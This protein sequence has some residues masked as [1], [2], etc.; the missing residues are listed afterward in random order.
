[1]AAISKNG[2]A[3]GVALSAFSLSACAGAISPIGSAD[4]AVRHAV[5]YTQRFTYRPEGQSFV[6]PGQITSITVIAIGAEGGAA[7]NRDTLGG[8]VHAVIPVVPFEVLKVY[9]GGSGA[10]L[11][12]GFNGGGNGGNSKRACACGYGGGGASDVRA[13]GDGLSDRIIVAAGGGGQGG[14]GS[15]NVGGKGGR[16]GGKHGASGLPGQSASSFE[17]GSGGSGGR[18]YG[19]GKGGGGGSGTSDRGEPGANGALGNGGNGGT[20]TGG[21]GGG[22]YYGGGG[23]GSGGGTSGNELAGGGGGGGSS[24]VEPSASKIHVARGGKTKSGN[25]LIVFTW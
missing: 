3:L 13:N 16:G 1:M 10:Y 8:R 9:V 18:R 22:G 21:G 17:G 25:G 23:G 14:S 12:G 7:G 20:S 15:G 11:K 2:A 5:S 6:V 24:Y 4:G 19:P